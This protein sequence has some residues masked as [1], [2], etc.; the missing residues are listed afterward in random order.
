MQGKWLETGAP[1]F[2]LV[3]YESEELVG[4][5]TAQILPL[6]Q[7]E[8]DSLIDSSKYDTVMYIL[9]LGSEKAKRRKGIASTLLQKA[10]Q[11]AT[12]IPTCGAVYLHVKTDNEPATTF[13]E[14]NGFDRIKTL[15]ST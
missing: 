5:I 13:Y 4:A 12:S 6:K 3:A 9:T 2:T 1:L 15:S 8:H 14:K 7:A 11:H 10:V